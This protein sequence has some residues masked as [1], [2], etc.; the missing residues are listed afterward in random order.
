MIEMTQAPAKAG[1]FRLAQASQ[2]ISFRDKHVLKETVM[3]KLMLMML[4]AGFASAAFA[5]GSTKCAHQVSVGMFDK[6]TA[7][8]KPTTGPKTTHN[9]QQR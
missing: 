3:K 2:S 5:S 9:G 8:V 6:T 1:V 7:K 4:V